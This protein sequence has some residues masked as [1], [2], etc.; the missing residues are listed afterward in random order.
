MEEV[1]K[2]V[3][4]GRV[5]SERTGRIDFNVTWRKGSVKDGKKERRGIVKTSDCRTNE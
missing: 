4:S 5:I 1:Y 2:C 3:F